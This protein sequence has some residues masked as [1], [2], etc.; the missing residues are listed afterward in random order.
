VLVV[1]KAS[2]GHGQLLF[3]ERGVLVSVDEK[4]VE[5]DQ[6]GKTRSFAIG[7]LRGVKRPNGEVI[8]NWDGGPAREGVPELQTVSD[9]SSLFSASE[10]RRRYAAASPGKVR[11]IAMFAAASIVLAIALRSTRAGPGLVILAI[12]YLLMLLGTFLA[13]RSR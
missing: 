7:D 3:E 9:W 6:A 1:A 11:G 8:A 10:M 12:L 2:G 4:R 13:K 5:I